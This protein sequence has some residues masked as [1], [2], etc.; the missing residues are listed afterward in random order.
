[1]FERCCSARVPGW[2]CWPETA[3]HKN[4]KCFTLNTLNEYFVVI[5]VALNKDGLG[6][7]VTLDILLDRLP[8]RPGAFSP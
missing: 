7:C 8:D 2:N 1:M 6:V 4:A 3:G 5:G